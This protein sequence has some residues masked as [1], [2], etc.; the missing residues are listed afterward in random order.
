MLV[1][2]DGMALP[3]TL[4]LPMQPQYSPHA[5]LPWGEMFPLGA[6][7]TT[8]NPL[9]LTHLAGGA[10]QSLVTAVGHTTLPSHPSLLGPHSTSAV[11]M[12]NLVHPLSTLSHPAALGSPP[13]GAGG[14]AGGGYINTIPQV[15]QLMPIIPDSTSMTMMSKSG[16]LGGPSG[17]SLSHLGNDDHHTVGEQSKA[18]VNTT[19]TK[20]SQLED[21]GDQKEEHDYSIPPPEW[22]AT[23]TIL[24]WLRWLLGAIAG[25]LMVAG[26]TMVY[27][28]QYGFF[29]LYDRLL[30]C[31]FPP[32]DYDSMN[33]VLAAKVRAAEEEKAMRG[34]LWGR[35]EKT[36]AEEDRDALLSEAFDGKP[37]LWRRNLTLHAKY[38]TVMKVER[39]M[40]T[41]MGRLIR[42]YVTDHELTVTLFDRIV[43]GAGLCLLLCPFR[44]YRLQWLLVMLFEWGLYASLGSVLNFWTDWV[45]RTGVFI[46][47]CVLF[48]GVTYLSNP[49]LEKKDRILDFTGRVLICWVGIGHIICSTSPQPAAPSG[50]PIEHNNIPLYG[51]TQGFSFFFSLNYTGG[52]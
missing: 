28:E 2:P 32:I 44:F 19:F 5:A 34:Y 48:Y 17:I 37:A 43:D 16:P 38:L 35:K 33:P 25:P 51:S 39:Q 29:A 22:S 15:G 10:S 47:I 49:Y 14:G 12:S 20:N 9:L 1:G 52:E 18:S 31:L 27:H 13:R 50:K 4:T 11:E 30:L 40:M 26:E 24:R 41:L 6:D 42:E 23:K 21:D 8:D 36:A 7:T 3:G 46:G 45:T